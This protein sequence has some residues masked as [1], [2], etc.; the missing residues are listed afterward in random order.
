MLQLILEEFPHA[1]YL[2]GAVSGEKRGE[3][4]RAFQEG[5]GSSL[6]LLSLKAGGVGLNL[7]A[8]DTVFLFD[9]WWNEAVERQA[10]DRAHRIGQKK[11]VIAKR[12]LVVGS[13]EEKMLQLKNKKQQ[14][15]DQLLDFEG[16]GFTEEDLLSLLE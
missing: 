5:E 2:D 16:G 14:A 10:I 11:T 1:L 7:T 15:A 8:A 3:L 4:V 12:Y 13:I 6:F 9:P